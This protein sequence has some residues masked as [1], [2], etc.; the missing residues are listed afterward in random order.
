MVSLKNPL[1]LLGTIILLA[2]V[3]LVGMRLGASSPSGDLRVRQLGQPLTL[4]APLPGVAEFNRADPAEYKGLGVAVDEVGT[5]AVGE[6]MVV[7]TGSL[8]LKVKDTLVTAAAVKTR[9]AEL[10]GFVLSSNIYYVGEKKD[11]V[12][13]DIIIRLPVDQFAAVIE[14][15]RGLAIKVVAEDTRGRDVTEEYVDLEAR[16]RNQEAT[17]TQLLRVMER[18]I[19]IEDVLAVQREL[20]RV[21]GEI[22]RLR[23]QM[24][25][26]ERSSEMATLSVFI[27]TEEGEL[28]LSETDW[29]PRTVA[30]RAVRA[31]VTFWR[32][33]ADGIIYLGIFLAPFIILYAVV[34]RLRR[35]SKKQLPG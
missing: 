22:E 29:R 18:A 30:R 13:A 7:R 16:L 35:R 21:R 10:G 12:V 14:E 1:K 8:S 5:D 31:L 4:G 23:G 25:Y 15:F 17:E 28:P 6:R 24:Q 32:Q 27:A 33:I 20:T 26:L 19:E 34:R 3:L 11:Q 9:A 2:V